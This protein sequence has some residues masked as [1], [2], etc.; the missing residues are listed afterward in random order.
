MGIRLACP[1]GHK[2]HVKS[3]L[4][5]K[6]GICP[7]CGATF[8]IPSNA[9][10]EAGDSIVGE[11]PPPVVALAAPPAA[12]PAPDE[13]AAAAAPQFPA[14]PSLPPPPSAPPTAVRAPQAPVVA[15]TPSDA[16][17]V[18]LAHPVPPPPADV[19]NIEGAAKGRAVRLS[20]SRR[21]MRRRQ[22]ALTIWLLV[23]VVV[24]AGLLVWVL[25]RNAGQ[26]SA[27]LQEPR[28][29]LAEICQSP[30]VAEAGLLSGWVS[31]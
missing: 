18:A 20:L 27:R 10:Q 24:L 14:A 25:T 29:H 5:G 6:R 3:F 26:T 23:L 31:R 17:V 22:L 13:S 21:R 28:A 15:D 7:E 11:T 30:Y 2:L 4:A 12:E 9:G 1:N 16:P 8:V 19:E